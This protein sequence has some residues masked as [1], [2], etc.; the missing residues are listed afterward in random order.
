MQDREVLAWIRGQAGILEDRLIAWSNINS[1]STNPIGLDR[2]AERIA[3]DYPMERRSSGLHFQQHH[4]ADFGVMLCGHMDTVFAPDH[5][6]QIAK[7]AGPDEINGPGVADMKGGL[8]IML[9]ALSAVMQTPYR[10]ALNWEVTINTDEEVGSSGSMPWMLERAKSN[11]I[12]LVFE[13]ALSPSGDMVNSRKGSGKFAIIAQGRAA[14][15][16]RDFTAGRNAIVGLAEVIQSIDQLNG[17]RDG[18]TLNIGQIS[19]GTA[20]NIVPDSAT[21]HIDIRTYQ[22]EDEDWLQEKLTAV[23]ASH[24]HHGD[25]QFELQGHF[26]RPPKR[27]SPKSQILFDTLTECAGE[28]NIPIEWRPSGGCCDGNNLA[29]AGL[30]VI[31]SLGARGNYIHTEKEYILVSSL[32]ERAQLTALLLMRLAKDATLR[33]ALRK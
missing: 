5:P 32:V 8:L 21:A 11:D 3:A 29:A 28:L 7:K 33:Q 24:Q 13:P 22:P 9:T 27:V 1:G 31:D 15:A 2:M 10:N 25:I 12:A 14:H 23:I 26:G 30:A 16:G 20:L 19:G 4:Q 18:V 17:Q 6:F